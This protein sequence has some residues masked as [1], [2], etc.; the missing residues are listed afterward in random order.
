MISATMAVAAAGTNRPVMAEFARDARLARAIAIV[1]DTIVF[2]FISLVINNVYGVTQVTSGSPLASGMTFAA[3]ST[4]TVI[5]W[6]WLA[7]LAFLYFT[8][9]EATFGATPGKRWMG[10]RVVRADGQRLSVGAVIIRNLLRPLD[11]LP[12]FYLVGGF[13]VL[14]TPSSQRLGDLAARTTVVYRHRAL[15]PGATRTSSEVERRALFAA[16]ALAILFTVAF[17][18]FGRPPLVIQGFFNTHEMEFSDV[19]SYSLGDPQW[20]FATVTYPY[21]ATV[22]SQ[23]CTGSITLNWRLSWGPGEGSLLCLS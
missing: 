15:A 7:A 20:G 1:I 22:G 18:Y 16:L 2:A 17:N 8:I 19:T 21:R 14:V 13:A 12:V 6:P 3:Y 10:L 23:A 9:T 5:P 4:E 11:Y